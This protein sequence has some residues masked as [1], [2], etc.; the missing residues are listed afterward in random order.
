MVTAL[1][2]EPQVLIQRAAEKLKE[3][4]IEKPAF[5]GF[6]KT[7]PAAERPPEQ[8][9]FWFIRCASILR[10]AYVRT[11]VG[12]SRLR[13]HYGAN[14]RRGVRPSHH[15]RSGGS[16]IRKAMQALEKAGLLS[17][18]KIGRTLSPKGRKFMDGVAK[19]ASA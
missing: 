13:T 8:A 10:Q 2:V 16:I 14:E 1:D 15:R 4:K 18:Q 11:N 5:V 3:M 17:K 6:V 7:G 9:D 19:E 12:V